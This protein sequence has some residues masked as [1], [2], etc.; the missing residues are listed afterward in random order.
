VEKS[1]NLKF[2]YEGK[3]MVFRDGAPAGKATAGK[4]K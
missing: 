3:T 4:K 1:A 2:G